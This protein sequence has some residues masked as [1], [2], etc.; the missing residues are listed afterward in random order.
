MAQTIALQRGTTTCA[1]GSSVTLFTQS[2]GTATRVILN[3]LVWYSNGSGNNFSNEN[4]ILAHTSSGGY[5]SMLGYLRFNAAN[6]GNALQ[7]YAGQQGDI[8]T[9]MAPQG[10]AGSVPLNAIYFNNSGASGSGFAINPTGVGTQFPQTNGNTQIWCANNFWI[11]PSDTISFR[12][13][14]ASNGF[15]ATIGYSFTTITES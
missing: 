13:T 4:V 5:T 7:F 14:D 15:T 11:G 3:Q 1:S 9:Q 2:G 6:A 12:H 8:G 10:T